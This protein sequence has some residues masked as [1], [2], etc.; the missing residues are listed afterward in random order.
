MSKLS[1]MFKDTDASQNTNTRQNA[2][3]IDSNP[4]LC[5]LQSQLVRAYGGETKEVAAIIREATNS[6]KQNPR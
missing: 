6:L 2:P 4:L 1:Q 5:K 3:T